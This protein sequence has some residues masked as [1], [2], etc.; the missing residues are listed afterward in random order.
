MA[1]KDIL[2]RRFHSIVTVGAAA[3]EAMS[4]IHADLYIMGVTGV[5]PTAHSAPAISKRPT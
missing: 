5:H 1:S 3:I 2:R 4:H